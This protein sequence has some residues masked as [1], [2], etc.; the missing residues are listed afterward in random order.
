MWSIKRNKLS[1]CVTIMLPS[2]QWFIKKKLDIIFPFA[3]HHNRN[4]KTVYHK[5]KMVTL[6]FQ[7]EILVKCEKKK[8]K[9]HIKKKTSGSGKHTTPSQERLNYGFLMKT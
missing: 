9:I 2:V 6:Q 4:D 5:K 1:D 3:Y 8:K 7:K